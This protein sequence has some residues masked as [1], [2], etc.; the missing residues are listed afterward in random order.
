MTGAPEILAQVPLLRHLPEGVRRRLVDE[1]LS[2]RFERGEILFHEGDAATAVYALVSGS[3]KLVRYSP[4]G[5]E[6][7]LHLVH[8]GQSFAEA[9]LFGEGTYPATAEALERSEVWFWP[10][11]QLVSLIGS[12]PEMALAMVASISIWTRRLARKLEN[13]TQRRVEERLAMYLVGRAGG[14]RLEPGE[15]IGLEEPRHLIAAQCGTAPEV[16]S[17][18]FRRLEEARILELA[19]GGIRITDPAH[20]AALA[21]GEAGL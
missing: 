19:P 10:R 8:P 7:L 9:A 14:R 5:K 4:K 12:S 2:R 18:T 16:L 17:R 15:L 13:L 11:E 20:L 6:L 3:V 21:A 1:G